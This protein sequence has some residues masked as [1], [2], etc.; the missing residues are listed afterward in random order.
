MNIRT[1]FVLSVLGV[2]FGA[3]A[4][5]VKM[6]NGLCPGYFESP[7][8]IPPQP[9]P[10]DLLVWT[11]AANGQPDILSLVPSGVQVSL[12]YPKMPSELHLLTVPQ[13]P[14][15]TDGFSQSDIFA[16]MGRA[17]PRSGS[18][19]T[20]E[21]LRQQAIRELG[22][23]VGGS[24]SF[25]NTYFKLSSANLPADNGLMYLLPSVS[26][27]SMGGATGANLWVKSTDI[28]QYWQSV[29]AGAKKPLPAG[30]SSV[31]GAILRVGYLNWLIS[32]LGMF[33]IPADGAV[34]VRNVFRSYVKGVLDGMQTRFGASAGELQFFSS[35]NLGAR[36]AYWLAAIR[37]TN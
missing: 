28:A 36:S 1:L 4:Y 3:Q 11:V 17:V 10:Y 27:L 20:A 34:A 5:T 9:R 19:L 29:L 16:L 7:Q 31:R 33:A 23:I 14:N 6:L 21:D 37:S 35:N 22:F 8:E 2:S 25:S 12:S 30:S 32:V 24:R 15:F 18:G 26:Q 13:D